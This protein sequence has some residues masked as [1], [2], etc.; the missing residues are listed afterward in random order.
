M[1]SNLFQELPGLA[2][3]WAAEDR[4]DQ[5]FTDFIKNA[6]V[7]SSAI[8]NMANAD[9]RTA[10]TE[11]YKALTPH[12]LNKA[13]FATA[14]RDAASAIPGYHT[15]RAEGE[16]GEAKTKKAKGE[17]DSKTMPGKIAAELRT[18]EI[19]KG[20]DE[21]IGRLSRMEKAISLGGLFADEF[22]DDPTFQQILGLAPNQRGT[23][24]GVLKEALL[25][26]KKE[27]AAK[28]ADAL[29]RHRYK[30][31]ELAYQERNA[32]RR[33]QQILARADKTEA[34]H[35]IGIV[36]KHLK[37]LE[38]AIKDARRDAEALGGP[39][40][41]L[42][43]KRELE[44]SGK[45]RNPA[46]LDKAVREEIAKREKEIFRDLVSERN[47]YQ[48]RLDQLLKII[49]EEERRAYEEPKTPKDNNSKPNGVSSTSGYKYDPETKSVYFNETVIATNVPSKDE[50]QKIVN[51]H[52]APKE[53]SQ[54]R[55]SSGDTGIAT[56]LIGARDYSNPAWGN[57]PA[58]SV[59]S[60]GTYLSDQA[61]KENPY[62]WWWPN[63]AKK[64]N[65]SN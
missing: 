43:I 41:K 10:E 13:A 29:I 58:E 36:Q 30:M 35:E 49:P 53:V 37:T 48:R 15:I 22:K 18:Q 12:E 55:S 45:Y 1:A 7:A 63:P 54:Q 44:N 31:D 16:L 24:F 34:K 47:N 50:A 9:Y 46:D 20:I 28:F 17:F 51:Q 32:E 60:V 56:P 40:N 59:S 5:D 11:R 33:H 26:R 23:M 14:G 61:E 27:N 42:Q 62:F 4:E 21:E 57:S 64:S 6:Q 3:L 52:K 19:D 2:G 65:G 38:T 25:S 8:G 39:L